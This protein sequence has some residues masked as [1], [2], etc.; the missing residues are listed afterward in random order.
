MFLY[1]SSTS[2]DIVMQNPKYK[3]FT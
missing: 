1:F 2:G 3:F